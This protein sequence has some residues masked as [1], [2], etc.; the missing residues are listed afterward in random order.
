MSIIDLA[1]STV[2]L[3]LLTLC[4]IPEDYPSFSDHELIL[5][6]WED[7]SYDLPN[8]ED[9]IPTG[10]DIHGLTKSPDDLE[11]ARINWISQS[12][13]R[14]L[15]DQTSNRRDLDEEVDWVEENLAEVLNAH[16]KILRV[17]SFS[18]RWWNKEVA[19]AR[20]TWA[21][22][23]RK[24]GTV[25]PDTVKLKQAR[26]LFYRVVRKAKRQ[27]WQNFLQGEDKDD[28]KDCRESAKDRCWTAL[29]YT[30]PKQHQTVIT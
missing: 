2:E 9:A 21:R 18:K 29:Q 19:E 23:K 3:G 5:L 8:K 27:C 24:W 6:R 17:T 20:K 4:K 1:L 14:K 30:Q 16:A 26:N 11:S 15:L 22:A 12:K 7:I 10:W 13:S 25:T 28:N